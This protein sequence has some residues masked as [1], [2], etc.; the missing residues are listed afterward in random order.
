MIVGTA[1]HVNHGKTTLVEALTGVACDRLEQER[2]RGMTIE[3][4][5]APWTLPD[6]RRVSVIDVPG[7]SKFARTMAAGALGVQVAV[8][9]IAADEGWMPQTREH[10]AACRV[11]GVD[12]AVVALTRIDRVPD[13]ATSV[14]FVREK[15]DAT[16]FAG[17][18]IVRV[19]APMGEG[20]DELAQRVAE[21]PDRAD[22]D[23]ALP[24][25]LPIDRVFTQKGFGTVITGSLLRGAIAEGDRLAVF[26]SG[27]TARVRQIHVHGER[28]E[29]AEARSRV[30]LNLADLD[31]NDAPR[32]GLLG[33]PDQV[34]VGRVF[35]AQIEWLA[36]NPEPLRRAR[37]LGWGQ[38]PARAAADVVAAP[39]IAPGEIGVG[40]VHLDRDVA[41][42][43]GTRFVL[44]GPATR[45]YGA[46]VGGGRILDAAP[47]RRR[48]AK[49]RR[50]LA[51]APS[52]EVLLAEAGP[53]GVDPR[54]VGAR[55]G[56]APLAPGPLRF[57]E[58]AVGP[59]ADALVARVRAHVAEDPRGLPLD[60]AR[61]RPIDE[62]AIA[63]ALESGAL[64]QDGTA[65]RPSGHV[66][67]E[68][69]AEALAE[70]ALE[71]LRAHGLK[72]PREHE[73]AGALEVSEAQLAE[74]LS[75]L[76][77]RDALVRSQGFCFATAHLHPLRAEV[78][79]AVVERG[80]LPFKYLKQHG[81]LSRKHAMPLWTW[82]DRNGVT[83]RQGERRVPGPAA[84][85]WAK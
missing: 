4:G 75:L 30:A 23:R 69:P 81:D 17:A 3:L 2:A 21:V 43:G 9:V 83:M 78:A 28:V 47:P 12:R 70:R 77:E 24:P 59:R 5:F 27:G 13:P 72:A 36:H 25:L 14:R 54:S 29:R 63:R 49:V 35:D 10:V 38:G 84:R 60:E 15:L 6:G 51:Q 80:S 41:L 44:R 76:E 42:V 68:S 74:A 58:S 50:S 66:V 65:L 7:H 16:H 33:A 32:G 48:S 61:G 85:R 18:P 26:P 56:L 82:L 57:A 22:D 37:S 52:I 34:C 19:C 64:V 73:L 40:R 53:R 71:A 39:A 20:L 46:V 8:L 62:A 1:G 67:D 45:R 11:L 79:R 31:A 55:L